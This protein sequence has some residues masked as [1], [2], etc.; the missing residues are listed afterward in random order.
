MVWMLNVIN[1][2]ASLL[3][4][5]MVYVVTH[6]DRIIVSMFKANRMWDVCS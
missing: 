6:Q 1:F 5:V 2:T 4:Y 3:L